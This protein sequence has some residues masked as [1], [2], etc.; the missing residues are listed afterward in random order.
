VSEDKPTLDLEAAIAAQLRDLRLGAGL[1]QDRL[2]G[3]M[4]DAG[5]PWYQQTVARIES[6]AQALRLSELADL[7]ALFGITPAS[8]FAGDA[9]RASAAAQS[10]IEQVVRE[11]II[12]ELASGSRR[13]A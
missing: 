8:L 2:A 13:V 12:A 5:H 11:R 3:M 7:A 6:G 4:A 10:A 9:V 1:S